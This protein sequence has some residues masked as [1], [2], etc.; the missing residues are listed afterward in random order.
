MPSE[1][2]LTLC[3][4]QSRIGIEAVDHVLRRVLRSDRD[5]LIAFDIGDGRAARFQVFRPVSHHPNRGA[6][7]MLYVEVIIATNAMCF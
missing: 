6:L 1:K 4:L 7:F 5:V 2:C 3:L